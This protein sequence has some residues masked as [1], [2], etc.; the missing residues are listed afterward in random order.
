[1]ALESYKYSHIYP[2]AKLAGREAQASGTIDY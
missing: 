2:S 1:M